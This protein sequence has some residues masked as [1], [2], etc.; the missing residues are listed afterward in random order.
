MT[1]RQ[2]GRETA[3]RRSRARA[4]EA[5]VAVALG[6]LQH[7]GVGFDRER[8]RGQIEAANERVEELELTGETPFPGEAS[9]TSISRARRKSPTSYTTN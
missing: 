6:V 3:R 9:T 8:A 7:R 4:V 2:R 5:K 1:T